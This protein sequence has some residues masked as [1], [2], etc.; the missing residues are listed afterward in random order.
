[1]SNYDDLLRE[2]ENGD[3]FNDSSME[4]H[5]AAL[6]KIIDTP[7]QQ[8]HRKYGRLLRNAIAVAAVLLIAFL[9]YTFLIEKKQKPGNIDGTI[10]IRPGIV[11]PLSGINVPYE[12]FSFNATTGDTLFTLNGSIIIFPR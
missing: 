7:T 4:K 5:W 1:M 6:E 9:G 12:T 10:A 11:P 3:L 8:P 2:K